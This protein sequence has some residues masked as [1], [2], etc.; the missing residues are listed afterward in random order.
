MEQREEQIRRRA[1]EKWQA[2]GCP[3]NESLRFWTEAERE[4]K[5]KEQ[6]SSE[7]SPPR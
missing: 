5:E 7:R 1:Y 2:A 6:Q 3:D 4:V